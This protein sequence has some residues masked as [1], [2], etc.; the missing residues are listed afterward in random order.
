[1]ESLIQL[2]TRDVVAYLGRDYIVEGVL[3]YKV[4]SKVFR[5]ARAVDGDD[6]L[7]V[8]P[9]VDDLDDRLLMF[10]EVKDLDVATPPPQSI[11]YR[12]NAFLPRWSGRATVEVSGKVP[13]D[14]GAGARE[15][16][17][18]RAAGDLFLHIEAGAGSTSVLYGE[19]VHKGMVDVLP[20]R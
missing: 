16:W 7:W 15:V 11:L 4:A 8:E 10:S 20:G 14:R 13:T 6:V 2:R 9:L 1:M 17:R 3:T 5:L 19:S 18:Y 12:E